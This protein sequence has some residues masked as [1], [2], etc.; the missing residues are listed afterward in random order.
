MNES[1]K[2]LLDD[3]YGDRRSDDHKEEII[4]F[5]T[6]YCDKVV[7]IGQEYLRENAF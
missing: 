7:E 4:D 3:Y 6:N 2:K 5:I 1:L